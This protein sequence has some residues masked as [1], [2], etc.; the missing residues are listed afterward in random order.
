MILIVMTETITIMI[1]EPDKISDKY[2][3][4]L[5]D[6]LG[7]DA[8]PIALII[9]CKL[10]FKYQLDIHWIMT[11]L[12]EGYNTAAFQASQPDQERKY[13]S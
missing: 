5:I 6:D 4:Q 2:M 13:D 7:T 10:T 9:I 8:I 11:A 1:D 3:N 12:L